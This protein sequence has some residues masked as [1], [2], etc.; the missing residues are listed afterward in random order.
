MHEKSG[1]KDHIK[2]IVTGPKL[3]T[4]FLDKDNQ[5]PALTLKKRQTD[6]RSQGAI[7]RSNIRG[8]LF[9]PTVPR[10]I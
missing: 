3:D 4:I 6:S 7:R 9:R 8:R 1:L 10:I 5:G 2:R